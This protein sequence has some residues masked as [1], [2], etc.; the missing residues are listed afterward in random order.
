MKIENLPEEFI[1]ALPVIEVIE[2]A[3]FDAYFVGGSVRD[4]VL[5]HD[6]HD[7]DIA[8]S[9]FPE[10]VKQLF[11]KTIDVGIKH[12]TVLVLFGDEQYEITT[13]RA[14][15]TYQDFRR[16]DNVTFVR[17]LSEDLKR[18]DFTMNA[19]AMNRHGDV[20]DLF[21]GIKAIESK[22]IIAVGNPT[23]RF[24]EDALRMMR[25]LRFSSQ[26]NFTIEEK[27]FE[28]I[29]ANHQLLE[30]ISVER[31]YI[32]W[33]KLVLGENRTNGLQAFI[34]TECFNYCPGLVNKKHPLQTFIET[35]KNKPISSEELAW[36]LLLDTLKEPSPAIF[37][38]KWK[39]SNKVIHDV[40]RGLEILTHRKQLPWDE[41]L[42]YKAGEETIQLVE[43]ALELLGIEH[44]TQE[45]LDSYR[46]LPIHS[47]KDLVVTG[48]DLI[49]E[50]GK[51]AGPWVGL[52]LKDIEEQ[53]VSGCLINNDTS[54]LNYVKETLNNE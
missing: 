43:E 49:K 9:A 26:L 32:E 15:S 21:N 53:V 3:G 18:R 36:V 41:M 17:S 12:G 25:A 7:V 39:A 52:L 1:N 16:P 23:E 22:K 48:T 50:S 31:I 47:I 45:A 4:I 37:L 14:E 38:K 5:G 28:A 2:K 8:T 46:R 34:D 27:T 54:I 42:L 30:K 20:I 35:F 44:R 19:L 51:S 40:T 24:F 6:I 10:E 13:F 11:H 29:Q 33:M